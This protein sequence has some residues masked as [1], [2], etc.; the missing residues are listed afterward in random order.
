MR[1]IAPVRALGP[2]LLVAVASCGG[3]APETVIRETGSEAMLDVA[4]AWA[5]GYRHVDRSVEVTV[6]GG[7]SE[8]GIASLV[9]GDAEV[10]DASRAISPEE[11]KGA[12]AAGALPIEHIVGYDA[13]VVFLNPANPIDS[14]TVPQLAGIFGEGGSVD[15]WSDLGVSVPGCDGKIVREGWAERSGTYEAFEETVLGNRDYKRDT[16]GHHESSDVT[17]A[18]ASTPCAIGYGSLAQ[19]S[20]G[21]KIPCVRAGAGSRCI[22]PSPSTAA[23]GRYPLARPLFVYTAGLP[24]GAI[25]R[26]MD[27][28][29]GSEGQCVLTET[30]YAPANPVD[31]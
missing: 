23:D 29:L 13:L 25:A 30:G 9:E 20:R 19:A 18:V 17:D 8:A 12:R 1:S 31:C 3:G 4:H 26:Y 2:I 6:S 7:G 14:M 10:A 24:E 22:E 27:W 16:L 11:L 5:E 21:V 15:S 28:I